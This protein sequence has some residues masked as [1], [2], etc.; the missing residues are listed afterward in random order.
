MWFIVWKASLL[1]KRQPKGLINTHE[2]AIN[3][4]QAR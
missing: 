2:N 4:C 1:E 3:P